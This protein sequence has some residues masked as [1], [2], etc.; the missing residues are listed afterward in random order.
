MLAFSAPSID[1][2]ERIPYASPFILLIFREVH[3]AV[4]LEPNDIL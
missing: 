4:E 3:I 1:N 2:S